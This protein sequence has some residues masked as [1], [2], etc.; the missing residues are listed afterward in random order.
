MT[1]LLAETSSLFAVVV[2]Q[3]R[4]FLP[5][6]PCQ[7]GQ[8]KRQ[9][10]EMIALYPRSLRQGGQINN[11]SASSTTHSRRHPY[12]PFSLAVEREYVI[13]E[14]SVEQDFAPSFGSTG[15]SAEIVYVTPVSMTLPIR[16]W[17]SPASYDSDLSLVMR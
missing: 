14:S 16:K 17:G 8:P 9:V 7:P 15:S 3:K 12:L 13:S 10:G 4:K 6:Y 11:L 5:R 2:L 1:T